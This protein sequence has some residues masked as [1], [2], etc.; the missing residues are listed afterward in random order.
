M[1]IADSGFN[2]Q[3]SQI[4][5]IIHF[6]LMWRPQANRNISKSTYKIYILGNQCKRFW[7]INFP[8]NKTTN[9]DKSTKPLFLHLF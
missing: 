5:Q 1:T 7:L 2:P 9:L 3:I 6:I 8:T 4:T